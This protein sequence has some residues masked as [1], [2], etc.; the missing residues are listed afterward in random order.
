MVL[1]DDDKRRIEELNR[2]AE[3]VDE[4]RLFSSLLDVLG[5]R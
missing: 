3:G 2:L 1:S 5:F 4:D